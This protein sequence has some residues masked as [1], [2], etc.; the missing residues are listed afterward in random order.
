MEK[1]LTNPVYIGPGIWISA[2]KLSF[3][4]DTKEKKLFFIKYMKDICHNFPCLTCRGHCS[5]YNKNNPIENYFDLVM[6]ID[7]KKLQLGMFVWSWKFH[8]AVN[9]RLKKSIVDWETAYNLYCEE[10]ELV[11]TRECSEGN[12]NNND[13]L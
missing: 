4:S 12:F 10:D 3:I 1:D 7:G 11:C 2:H 5:E 13:E 6:E 8:N 9:L